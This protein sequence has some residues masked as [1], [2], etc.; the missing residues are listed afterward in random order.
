MDGNELDKESDNAYVITKIK[1]E[2]VCELWY[3]DIDETLNA[4][5]VSGK[6][7]IYRVVKIT[8]WELDN[9]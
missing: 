5:T 2:L 6:Y 7:Y 3:N 9:E 4:K 1:G 8:D